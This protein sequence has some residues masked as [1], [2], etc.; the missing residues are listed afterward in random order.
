MIKTFFIF[1]LIGTATVA[2]ADDIRLQPAPG[3]RVI[4][5]DAD[6]NAVRLEVTETGVLRIPG[7]ADKP[8]VDEAPICY[9][10]DTGTLGNCPPG[11]VEGPPGPQG[12]I[13]PEGPR[14][15]QG[16]IGPQGAT[17]PEGP[18]GPQGATGPEGPP[19]ARGLQGEIGPQGPAV[20]PT[21]SGTNSTQLG[22][23]VDAAGTNSTALGAGARATLADST[24][25]GQG[26][27]ATGENSTALGRDSRA[28]QSNS[29]ALG[30]LA[31]ANGAGSTALGQGAVAS[32][33][34]TAIG[35]AA[36]ATFSNST[37][38]GRGAFANADNKVR[39]GNIG[40]AVIEGNVAFSP[41]SDRRLKEG[42][43][44]SKLGLD[45]INDL[46]PVQYRRISSPDSGVEFGLIAQELLEALN[47]S[48]LADSSMVS[49]P[50]N[51]GM[52]SVRYNDL[53][54][55]L[56]SAVQELSKQNRDLQRRIELLEAAQ[57]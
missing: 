37:A 4:I 43:E 16:D 54:A 21:G 28:T 22:T 3:S 33:N 57:K 2:V 18:S 10:Q 20:I 26:A 56:I 40:V 17:G 49:V 53:L 42:I 7:L 52:M 29:T 24:A 46:N 47:N 23:G 6:G 44:A 48:N 55:P 39:I 1:L 36:Q 51:D 34:S 31:S 27:E 13:G 50:E 35:Q 19:G 8:T 45:F 12:E 41:T 11:T 25:V 38:L 5:T 14:G 9:D 30:R 15:P 32:T